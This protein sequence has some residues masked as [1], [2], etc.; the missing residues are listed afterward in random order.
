MKNLLETFKK[1]I[2]NLEFYSSVASTSLKSG[3]IF[4]FKV[5]TSLALLMTVVFSIFLVPNGVRFIK[6]Q[7]PDLVKKYYPANLVVTIDKGSASSNVIEPYVI[8]TQGI[9]K[10]VFQGTSI[11]NIFVI[12][13]KDGV[14][15][16]TFADYKTF[17]LLTRNE[18][19]TQ[20]NNTRVSTLGLKS[21][22]DVVISEEM[23]LLAVENVRANLGV[24]VPAG[25]ALTF[26]LLLLGFVLHLIPLFL[27]ALIPFFL[28]WIKKIPLTYGGSYRMSLYAVMPGL[29]L[30]SLLNISGFFFVPA[31]LSLLVF[32]LIIFVNMRETEQPNLF[33]NNPK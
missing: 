17:A 3:I 10:E 27:F 8:P 32:M 25:I 20:G 15:G 13:T 29:V 31:Y 16:K 4:Y 5:A 33:E 28:A 7:A 12:D 22:P 23:L 26:M 14:S 19:M 30:K 18:V 24:F 11:E 6:E 2:Y 9:A 1:S 21:V